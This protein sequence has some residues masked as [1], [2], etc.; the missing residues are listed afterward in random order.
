MLQ[1][2][3]RTFNPDKKYSGF[4]FYILNK[5]L[6][7]GK[8]LLNSCPNCF[9]CQCSN[10]EEMQELYWLLFGLWKGKAFQINLTGSVIP[11]IRMKEL[12]EIIQKGISKL[13][14][15]PEKVKQNISTIAKIEKQR[16]NIVKQIQ[17]IQ[18]L[19]LALIQDVL[20]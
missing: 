10:E 8:P 9:V 16:L 17:L 2:N 12:K 5:G 15:K 20:K 19:K 11:F 18:Q 6:N 1:Y 3:L 7:S 13:Q 14:E 4:H